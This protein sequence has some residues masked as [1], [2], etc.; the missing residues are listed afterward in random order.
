MIKF[1]SGLI[2][3]I[4]VTT[5]GFSGLARMADRGVV[6]VQQ[7]SKDVAKSDTADDVSDAVKKA[8]DRIRQ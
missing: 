6:K 4:V 1:F 5:I 7:I 3:G 2:L 8:V